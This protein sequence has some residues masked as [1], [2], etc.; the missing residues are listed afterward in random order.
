MNSGSQGLETLAALC[1]GV[2]RPSTQHSLNVDSYLASTTAEAIAPG[3]PIHH[4]TTSYEQQPCATANDAMLSPNVAGQQWLQYL[5]SINGA[6]PPEASLPGVSFPTAAACQSGVVA[7]NN[8]AAAF[9]QWMY[10][11]QG[12]YQPLVHAVQASQLAQQFY[13]QQHHQMPTALPSV[14]TAT[15]PTTDNLVLSSSISKPS[16]GSTHPASGTY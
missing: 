7:P 14:G 11:I 13:Q 10:N 8:L 4:N 3:M 9:C 2:T 6:Q 12:Q 1:G 5:A 15:V 16:D